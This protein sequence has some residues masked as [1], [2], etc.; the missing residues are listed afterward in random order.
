MSHT[1]ESIT[2]T[3]DSEKRRFIL[4]T[5]DGQEIAFEQVENTINNASAMIRCLPI[6]AEERQP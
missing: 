1:K 4:T 3:Y 6:R 2:V 5:W